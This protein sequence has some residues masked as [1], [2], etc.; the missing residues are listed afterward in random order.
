M[1]PYPN[2]TAY[3]TKVNK[4][5]F[6]WFH[7]AFFSYYKKIGTFAW[8]LKVF[9]T[10]FC[11]LL[12]LKSIKRTFNTKI[13]KSLDFQFKCIILY[14]MI[15]SLQYIHVKTF[16]TYWKPHECKGTRQFQSYFADGPGQNN[17]SF[18]LE[19]YELMMGLKGLVY[20]WQQCLGIRLIKYKHNIFVKE[21]VYNYS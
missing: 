21:R 19:W 6:I 13:N 17:P 5:F 18:P 1:I 12:N 14:W 11:S 2:I 8:L 7:Y 9:S 16:N 3:N 10:L 4:M 20:C 15:G